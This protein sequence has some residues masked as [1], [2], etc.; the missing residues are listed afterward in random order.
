M[1]GMATPA[2]RVLSGMAACFSPYDRPCRRSDTPLAMSELLAGCPVPFAQPPTTSAA[3]SV[4]V[5]RACRAM[6]NIVAAD[7]TA[8]PRT[9]V[10]LLHRRAVSPA[11][12]LAAADVAK[13]PAASRPSTAGPKPRSSRSRT[14]STPTR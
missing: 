5:S 10:T 2:S 3:D 6:N 4:T 14:D 12:K 11:A 13:K 9:T 7:A 1:S 8:D